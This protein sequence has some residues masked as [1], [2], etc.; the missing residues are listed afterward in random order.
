MGESRRD[1]IGCTGLGSAES[2]TGIFS[3]KEEG[4]KRSE[5]MGVQDEAGGCTRDVGDDACRFTA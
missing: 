2:G 1:A 3:N 4:C 5:W